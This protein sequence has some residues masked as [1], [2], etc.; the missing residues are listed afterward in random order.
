MIINKREGLSFVQYESDGVTQ[1]FPFSFTYLSQ[2]YIFVRVGSVLT[3]DFTF[4]NSN[5]IRLNTAQ[6]STAGIFLS[7]SFHPFV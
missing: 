1:N 7:K 5:E 6:S 3:T 2:D 4:V